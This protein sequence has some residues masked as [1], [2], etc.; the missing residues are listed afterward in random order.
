MVRG[1]ASA[2]ITGVP[3]F[4][5]RMTKIEGPQAVSRQQASTDGIDDRRPTRF[6]EDRMAERKREDLVGTARRIVARLAI[7]DVVQISA[8]VKPEASIE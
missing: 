5:V 6:V 2:Q 4:E 7:D 3:R 1:I 8:V